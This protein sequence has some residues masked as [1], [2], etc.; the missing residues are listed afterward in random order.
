MKVQ[1]I[2]KD[3]K[4]YLVLGKRAIPVDGL[5]ASG[6]PIVKVDVETTPNENGGQDVTVHVPCLDIV[7]REHAPG[8]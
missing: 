6:K 8:Q 5:D 7:P 1:T 2:E 3:G 4:L